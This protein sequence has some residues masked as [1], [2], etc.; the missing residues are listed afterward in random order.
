MA[1]DQGEKD[2][3]CEESGPK[4]DYQHAHRCDR[5]AQ[6]NRTQ[7]E[8]VRLRSHSGCVC[9]MNPSH[10]SKDGRAG[11]CRY[12]CGELGSARQRFPF[13]IAVRTQFEAPLAL[14]AREGTAAVC[15]GVYLEHSGTVRLRRDSLG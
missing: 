12:G 4:E 2:R 11:E 5:E 13:P 14:R 3:S 7:V 10:V 15:P 8:H 6:M 9:L 1:R